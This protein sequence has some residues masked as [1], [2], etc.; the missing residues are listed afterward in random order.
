LKGGAS[1]GTRMTVK[2]AAKLM[3]VTEQYIRIGLQQGVFPWGYVV[4]AS[5]QYTYFINRQKF[6]E[7]EKIQIE[8]MVEV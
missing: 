1:V 5:S 7:H 4:K 2:E 8:R 3:E 6:L